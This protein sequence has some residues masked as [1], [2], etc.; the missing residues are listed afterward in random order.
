MGYWRQR[1]RAWLSLGIAEAPPDEIVAQ[2]D[3]A[4]AALSMASKSGRDPDFYSQK[5][6]FERQLGRKISTAEF[7]REHYVNV[8]KPGTFS[9]TG[10]SVFDPVL[11]EIAYRWF[12]PAGGRVLDPFAGGIM[13]GA[14]AAY[15]GR[16]FVGVELC[17]DVVEANRRRWEEVER[18]AP[19]ELESARWIEGDSRELEGLLGGEE[20]FDLAYTSPPY[21]DR[22]VYSEDDRDISNMTWEAF[23]EAY[24]AI[25]AAVV[26]RLAADRFVVWSMSEVRDRA[27]NY[28]GLGPET[29]RAFEDAGASYYNEAILVTPAGSWPI[30]IGRQ[31]QSGRKLARIHQN[32]LIFVKGDGRAAAAA[33]GEIEVASVDELAREL[34]GE[35]AEEDGG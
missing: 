17:G 32:I 18:T 14:V 31:F 28:R 21:Y 34:A 23:L 9:A 26:D 25:I 11:C 2:A 20:L 7:E 1:K 29:V 12:C 27:G 35:E 3:R 10:T 22:E 16:P 24:R 6:A 15:L 4:R 5:R 13:A 30:R 33:C 8:Q 19:V